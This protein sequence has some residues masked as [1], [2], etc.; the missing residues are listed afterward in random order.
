MVG[1][2]SF[3][4]VYLVRKRFL[5]SIGSRLHCTPSQLDGLLVGSISKYEV[6][7]LVPHVGAHVRVG[8]LG[9]QAVGEGSTFLGWRT[10]LPSAR[11]AFPRDDSSDLT[12]VSQQPGSGLSVAAKRRDRRSDRA[13]CQHVADRQAVASPGSYSP[14]SCRRDQSP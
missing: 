14:A 4:E 6:M 2:G 13:R 3:T 11:K 9:V 10:R 1:S 5:V 12:R 7:N 8:A